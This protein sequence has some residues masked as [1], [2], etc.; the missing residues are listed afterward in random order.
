[1]KRLSVNL[2]YIWNVLGL[3]TSDTFILKAINL[4]IHQWLYVK[5]N[6]YAKERGIPL[7]GAI[8][9]IL[10]EFLKNK[11]NGMDKNGDMPEG[12][13]DMGEGKGLLIDME[14]LRD[15]NGL[16][17]V[18]PTDLSKEQTIEWIRNRQFQT[19]SGL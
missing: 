5:L 10:A 18:P 11:P 13:I 14:K 2:S 15:Q 9:L 6:A 1:M 12:I 7:V 19:K 16:V 3:Y 17:Q 4:Q 8:R